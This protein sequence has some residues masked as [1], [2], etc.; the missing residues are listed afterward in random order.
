MRTVWL[1]GLIRKFGEPGVALVGLLLLLH[2][3][4]RRRRSICVVIGLLTLAILF[5]PLFF[6]CHVAEAAPLSYTLTDLGT[7]PGYDYA[8]PSHVNNAGQVVG[9]AVHADNRVRA[10]LWQQ[11]RMQDLGTL[12]GPFSEALSVND[13]GQIVG[14]SLNAAGYVRGFLWQ[15]G[16]MKDLGS[17]GGR[18]TYAE[19]INSRGDIVGVSLNGSGEYRAFL[20]RN[21]KMTSL[22]ALPKCDV[23]DAT[24][25]NNA[26]EA[27]GYAIRNWQDL[28]PFHY[29][30]GKMGALPTLG[31]RNAIAY[32]IDSR[33]R[34]VG[35]SETDPKSW[36]PYHAVLWDGGKAKDIGTLGGT[37]SYAAALNRDGIVVGAAMTGVQE[38]HAV[39]WKNGKATDLNRLLPSRPES[40]LFSAASI[41]DAGRIVGFGASGGKYRAYLLSP[42]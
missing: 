4:G 28:L 32:G 13:S 6:R 19:A 29:R 9:Y 34:S 24:G 42:E 8:V 12:G 26:G 10:F 18:F 20:Y 3:L 5:R 11:G 22:G 36:T 14:V 17:L 37:N 23:S 15:N 31:G 30:S 33:G 40:R 16:R 41:N 25:I 7:L 35:L 21:G 38:W 2:T 27:V 39:L 1:R